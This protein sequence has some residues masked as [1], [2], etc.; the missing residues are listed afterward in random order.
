MDER[1]A[2]EI[3]SAATFPLPF[4]VLFLLSCGVLA[5]ATNLHGLH[6]H[7]IDV[8][9]TLH[10]D[11][12]AL[13]TTRSPSFKRVVQSPLSY[14]PVYRLFS[15]CAAWCFSIWFIYRCSTLH[16][17]EYVDVF[18]YLPAVGTLGLVIGLVCPFDVLEL[19]ER[20]KF[21]SC[22]VFPTFHFTKH[23]LVY[24]VLSTGASHPRNLEYRSPTWFSQISSHLMPKFLGIFGFPYR[25]CSLGVVYSYCHL[26]MACPVG[27][28]RR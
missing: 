4:R 19:H 1:W 17:V 27:F 25:C 3:Q 16:H 12:S 15:Y 14:R 2:Q 11:R 9:S 18:K 6:L 20:E 22:A 13:P 7:A 5:W 26:R 24:A 28:C 23:N 10:P 21:L 8:S